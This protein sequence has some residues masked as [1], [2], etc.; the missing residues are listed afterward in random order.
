MNKMRKNKQ[1][2]ISLFKDIKTIFDI[3]N[4]HYCV[5]YGLLLGIIREGKMIEGDA[6]I[7]IGIWDTSLLKIQQNLDRFHKKEIKVHFTESGHVTFNRDNVHVSAMCFIQE[8]D[9]AKR[10]TFTHMRKHNNPNLSK[11]TQVLK[12]IRWLTMKPEYV[13]DSPQFIST[14]MQNILVNGFSMMPS[15]MRKMFKKIV[16]TILSSGCHYFVEEMP[17]VFLN[18]FIEIDFQGIKVNIPKDSEGY[19]E[20]KYGRDWMIP[21]KDYVYYRDSK[22]EHRTQVWKT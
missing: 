8:G 14:N 3:N 17:S 7:D 18:D 15:D 22:T 13:G 16:E 11:V 12:Y 21:K 20:Q 6:D 9:V 1:E 10:F 19:L 5:I 4:I 2:N